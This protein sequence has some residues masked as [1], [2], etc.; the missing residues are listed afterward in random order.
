MKFTFTH[1][2][3]EGH[4]KIVLTSFVD[5]HIQEKRTGEA[6][7]YKNMGTVL[8]P[9]FRFGITENRRFSGSCTASATARGPFRSL[10]SL[11]R[12]NLQNHI[13]PVLSVI[14]ESKVSLFVSSRAFS[15]YRTSNDL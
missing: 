7:N 1:I 12:T 9:E 11:K 6:R 3:L 13:L 10:R 4:L 2:I 15:C 8:P 14:I 5:H